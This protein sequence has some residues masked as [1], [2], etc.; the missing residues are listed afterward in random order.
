MTPWEIMLVGGARPR[1]WVWDDRI[2]APRVAIRSTVSLLHGLWDGLPGLLDSF[3]VPGADVLA[4]LAVV[5][6]TGLGLLWW[7]WREAIR[8][9]MAVGQD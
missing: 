3:L 5:S 8:L 6:A 7:R 2:D 9:Q 4:A 1:G